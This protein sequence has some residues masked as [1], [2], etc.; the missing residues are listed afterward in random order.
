MKITE[1]A[2]GDREI[3]LSYIAPVGFDADA[4]SSLRNKMMVYA[5]V[6]RVV[7]IR[8]SLQVFSN[9]D[10]H[11]WGQHGECSG[12]SSLLLRSAGQPTSHNQEFYPSTQPPYLL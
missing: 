6:R 2:A 7:C 1:D 9:R 8:N 11:S 5:E 4:A 12:R 3:F 10:G